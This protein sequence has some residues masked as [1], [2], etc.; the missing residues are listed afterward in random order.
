MLLVVAMFALE[1]NILLRLR[2]EPIVKASLLDIVS[3]L[4]FAF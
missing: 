2:E 1:R 4:V 3:I